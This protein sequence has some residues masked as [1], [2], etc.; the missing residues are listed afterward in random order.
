[1][2]SSFK[3]LTLGA[4][5]STAGGLHH[6]LL[7]GKEIGAN[8]V[9]IFTSNQRQWKGRLLTKEILDLWHQTLTEVSFDLIMS[10]ASYLINLGSPSEETLQK[11]QEAFSKELDRCHQLKISYLNFHPG[12]AVGRSVEECLES[13]VKSLLQLEKQCQKG[14]T[15]LLLESTAGQGTTVGFSFEQL[16]YIISRV[17]DKLPIG[18]CID[19]CHSFVAGYDLRS[20]DSFEKVLDQFELIIGLKHLYAFHVNDS[21]KDLGSHVDR[22]APLG[23]GKIGWPAFEFLI[24]HQRTR[25]LPMYLETPGGVENWKKEITAL[26]TIVDKLP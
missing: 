3:A 5:T 14:P 20:A 26:K 2:A 17:K 22:H 12:A 9:Q 10:H 1:V 7:Q 19:T 11:S 18:V 4:H 13:I 6:A 16:N 8:T 25:H 21:V 24:T 23:E 15:R